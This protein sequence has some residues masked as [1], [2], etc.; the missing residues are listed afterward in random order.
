MLRC[1]QFLQG[2]ILR[3][4]FQ[5]KFQGLFEIEDPKS[6]PGQSL[7]IRWG[8]WKLETRL[9]AVTHTSVC[10]K[11]LGIGTVHGF[12]RLDPV[13]R[14]P[15]TCQEQTFVRGPQLA[16]IFFLRVEQTPV[17]ERDIFAGIRGLAARGK[18]LYGRIDQD[19]AHGQLLLVAEGGRQG[20]RLFFLGEFQLN[21]GFQLIDRIFRLDDSV[22]AEE[23]ERKG[24]KRCVRAAGYPGVSVRACA[25][26]CPGVSVRARAA[27][28]PGVSI[29]VHPAGPF[30][31]IRS[32][33]FPHRAAPGARGISRRL[34]ARAGAC[35]AAGQ[36]CGQQA[37]NY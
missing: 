25:A 14:E 28:C 6:I 12:H 19:G 8:G 21:R 2:F 17:R 22:G 32:V 3:S 27:R 31:V 7:F 13:L 33:H 10:L 5:G 1:R 18:G 29:R 35:L 26:R 23:L 15:R 11:I 20:Q 34:T 30:H 16:L 36:Q 24:G 4:R 9:N 37:C